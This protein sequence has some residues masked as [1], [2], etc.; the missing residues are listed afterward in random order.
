LSVHGVSGAV[1]KACRPR[2][3][4]VGLAAVYVKKRQKGHPE[5]FGEITQAKVGGI[6]SA[7]LETISVGAIGAGLRGE[8]FLGPALGRSKGSHPVPELPQ[9]RIWFGARRHAHDA[10]PGPQE[11]L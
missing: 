5:G 4:Y 8:F 6:A 1:Y 7:G 11:R 3:T 10:D 2:S 9:G